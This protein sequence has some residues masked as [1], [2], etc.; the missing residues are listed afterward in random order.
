MEYRFILS[1]DFV[2]FRPMS[3]RIKLVAKSDDPML[4][5]KK[6]IANSKVLLTLREN[7]TNDNKT[8]IELETDAREAWKTIIQIFNSRSIIEERMYRDELKSQKLNQHKSVDLLIARIKILTSQ[9]DS[10]SDQKFSDRDKINI[11]MESIDDDIRYDF[12]CKTRQM[13]RSNPERFTFLNLCED[14][15]EEE[16]HLKLKGIKKVKKEIIMKINAPSEKCPKCLKTG[17]DFKDCKGKWT[18]SHC[19]KP[20]HVK[21]NCWELHPELKKEKTKR[22]REEKTYTS[23]EKPIGKTKKTKTK[24]ERVKIFNIRHCHLRG[25]LLTQDQPCTLKTTNR[26]FLKFVTDPPP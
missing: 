23:K 10:C 4:L 5:K 24:S 6:L 8:I 16:N 22:P 26:V 2:S 1:P 11:L 15:R 7:M 19:S 21:K 20:Y 17:H 18:C 13:Q 12:F 14:L 25:L 3:W 9:I